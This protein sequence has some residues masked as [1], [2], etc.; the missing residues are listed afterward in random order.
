MVDRLND[1]E[2]KDIEE[3]YG[4]FAHR[5]SLASDLVCRS[6]YFDFRAGFGLPDFRGTLARDLMM[7]FEGFLVRRFLFGLDGVLP[8]AGTFF[9]LVRVLTTGFL[10]TGFLA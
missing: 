8:P 6:V 5:R 2:M 4:E 7:R 1:N 10:A 3:C 9:F